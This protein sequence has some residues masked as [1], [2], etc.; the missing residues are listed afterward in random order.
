MPREKIGLA[1]TPRHWQARAIRGRTVISAAPG[2]GQTEA[3]LAIVAAAQ[4]SARQRHVVLV[5]TTA[6][7]TTAA[8]ERVWPMLGVERRTRDGRRRQSPILD[9]PPPRRRRRAPRT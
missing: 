6:A 8:L 3:A 9:Q 7:D 1:W 5:G 2:N 4:A